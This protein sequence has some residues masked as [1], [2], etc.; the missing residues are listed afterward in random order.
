MPDYYM[1]YD[2]PASHAAYEDAIANTT[3]LHTSSPVFTTTEAEDA[4]TIQRIVAGLDLSRLG[5]EVSACSKVSL[6]RR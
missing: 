4:V 5:V 1:N 3:I 6:S 2:H